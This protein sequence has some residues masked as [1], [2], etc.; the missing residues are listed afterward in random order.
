[1]ATPITAPTGD[2]I[3]RLPDV[4]ARVGISKPTLYRLL[5]E[6][7][8]FPRPLKLSGYT[9]GWRKSDIDR[10]IATRTNPTDAASR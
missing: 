6:G 4:L 3:L 1:M 7:G 2:V 8:D 5:R 10:W 9:V